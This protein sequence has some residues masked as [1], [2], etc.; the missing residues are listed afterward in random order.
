MAIETDDRGRVYLPK[1]I[2]NRHGERYRMVDLPSRIMLVPV[3]E[4]PLEAIQDEVGETL[5]GK[6]VD[7]LKQEARDAI[8]DDVD[9]EMQ[10][11]DAREQGDE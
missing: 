1:E 6:S 3:D 5:E 4:E 10:D 7:E 2:R 8:R 11:R 9:D